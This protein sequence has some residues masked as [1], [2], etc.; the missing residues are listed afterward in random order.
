M[1]KILAISALALAVVFSTQCGKKKPDTSAYEAVCA[2]VAKCD[3]QMQAFPDIEG[4]CAKLFATI[5]QKMPEAVAPTVE[6][7]NKA[8]CESL[9]FAS[10]TESLAK[11]MQGMIPAVPAGK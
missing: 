1:R 11:G 9:S 8:P 5:Q 10:C 6:C 7:I 4:H 2:K 3:K